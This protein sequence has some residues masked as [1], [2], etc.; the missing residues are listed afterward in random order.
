VE[1]VAGERRR[2]FVDKLR[3]EELHGLG[4]RELEKCSEGASI[5]WRFPAVRGKKKKKKTE[6]CNLRKKEREKEKG[7]MRSEKI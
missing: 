1:G 3:V 6:G 2:S 7:K 5:F 4:R